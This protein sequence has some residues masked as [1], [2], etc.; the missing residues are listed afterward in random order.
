MIEGALLALSV[1]TIVSGYFYWLVCKEMRNLKVKNV[2]H[3]TQLFKC[4]E[5]LHDLNENIVECMKIVH[6]V[7]DKIP[8]L[9]EVERL[10]GK[11]KKEATAFKKEL[12]S[13]DKKLEKFTKDLDTRVRN[14]CNHVSKIGDAVDRIKQ[15]SFDDFNE[16]RDM[17]ENE[18]KQNNDAVFRR[19]EDIARDFHVLA[20]KVKDGSFKEMKILSENEYLK[21]KKL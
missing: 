16:Y 17:V 1:G 20:T 8:N 2:E 21:L 19:L 13:Q 18:I 6:A 5:I 12:K 9:E 11:I 14:T 4:K 7:E 15:V 3:S 10:Y